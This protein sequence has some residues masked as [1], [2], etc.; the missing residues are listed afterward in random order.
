MNTRSLSFRLVTWYAGL[1]TVVFVALGA[2]T[3]VFLRHYLEANLLDIQGRRARQI[4]D[5]LL[6]AASR[7][8][9]AAMA[10]QVEDLYSPEANDRLIRITRGDGH[11]VYASGPPKDNGFDPSAV[12]PA[13]LTRDGAFSR[14]EAL[15]SG[16]LLVAAQ[17][18]TGTDGTRYVV[19]V[20]V[21]NARTEA[22]LRQ[23]LLMLAIGL[24]VA[25]S[26]AVAGGFILVRRALRP[27][28]QIAHK[29]S[30]SLKPAMNSSDCPIRSI[31]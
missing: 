21:S 18:Y 12:P 9:E 16:A 30:L 24:P 5:T 26:V 4:S 11:V 6:V 3:W 2:L 23:V 27:V 15:P 28:E 20:G 17:A 8:G 1:L 14:K 22:T 19:E 31:T 29:A 10:G 13:P 7:T 25:V